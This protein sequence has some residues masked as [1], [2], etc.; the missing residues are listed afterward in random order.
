MVQV[1]QVRSVGYSPSTETAAAIRPDY[2]L[3]VG[4]LRNTDGGRAEGKR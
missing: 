3:K 4:R 2:Y 1:L